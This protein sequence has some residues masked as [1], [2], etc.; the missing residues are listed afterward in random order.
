MYS[1]K[2]PVKSVVRKEKKR[3][4]IQR[5]VDVKFA[6][7]Y[8]FVIQVNLGNLYNVQEERWRNVNF[9]VYKKLK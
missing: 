8:Y 4:L 7:L 2:S 3:Y 9:E 5:G 6:N 1:P